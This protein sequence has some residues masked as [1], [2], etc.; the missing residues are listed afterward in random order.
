MIPYYSCWKDGAY[1][2]Y[3][4]FVGNQSIGNCRIVHSY[5][6]PYQKWHV[7]VKSCKEHSTFIGFCMGQKQREFCEQNSWL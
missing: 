3:C 2:I 7:S 6:K 4:A 5:L 1:L